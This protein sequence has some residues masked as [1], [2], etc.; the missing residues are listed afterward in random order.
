MDYMG[1]IA[2]ASGA[3]NIFL[4]M[5]L[6]TSD[7]KSFLIFRALPFIAG[8]AIIIDGMKELGWI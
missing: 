8:L 5:I 4:A 6:T 2:L 7:L 1:Y 3:L